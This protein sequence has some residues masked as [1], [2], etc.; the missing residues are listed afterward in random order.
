MGQANLSGGD[1]TAADLSSADLRGAR[2]N[3]AKLSG[4]VLRAARLDLADFTGSDLSEADLSEANWWR[5]NG[6]T[7]GLV[8]EFRSRFSPSRQA[9]EK[10]RA[11]FDAWLA[12]GWSD[13]NSPDSGRR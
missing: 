2:L 13:D 11:D 7:P 8:A 9:D 10:L 1:F 6:L 5:A 4:A 12:K 3:R